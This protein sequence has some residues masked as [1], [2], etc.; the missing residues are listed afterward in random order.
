MSDRA[1]SRA[2]QVRKLVQQ[3]AGGAKGT[4]ADLLPSIPPAAPPGPIGFPAQL[5][6]AGAAPPADVA[7]EALDR[8][9][10]DGELFPGHVAAL[11]AIVLPT[12]RPVIDVVGDSFTPPQ[13]GMWAGLGQHQDAI[14]AAIRATGRVEL[15]NHPFLPYGGTAFLIGPD[16]LL[17]NR[18]VAEAFVTGLGAR[19]LRFYPGRSA[20]VD[21]RQ[22]VVASDP[23]VLQVTSVLLVHP[24][25]DAAVFRV[26]GVPADRKPLA[27]LA[28]PPADGLQ[29][30]DAVVIGYP[31][32]DPTPASNPSLQIQIFNGVFQRKRLQPGR[33]TGY[34]EVESYANKVQA[35]AHDCSTL[36][37]NS[38]SVVLDLKTGQVIGLHFAGQY[39]VSNYAVP[40]WALA[41]DAH[42]ADLG[43]SLSGPAER[44]RD[45]VWAP[46]WAQVEHAPPSPAPAAAAAVATAKG[47]E[48]P[49]PPGVWYERMTD[50]DLALALERDPARTEHRLEQAMGPQRAQALVATLRRPAHTEGLFGDPEPDPDKPTIVYLHGILGAHLEAA[51]SRVWLNPLAILLDNMARKLMLAPDGQ[52]EAS[53][54][55]ALQAG[56]HIKL[57][58][59]DAARAWRRAGYP[60]R[61]FSYDWRKGIAQAADRLH[62]FIEMLNLERPGHPMV[63]AAHSM[64]GLVSALY[65]HRHA[66]WADRV[67]RAV[68]FGPPLGGSFDASMFVM[69]VLPL[70]VK[71]RWVSPST[72]LDQLRQTAAS[73]P[74]VIDLL[75]SREFFPE[76][77]L[78]YAQAGWPD[79][80]CRPAQRWLDQSRALKPRLVDAPI[81][82]RTTVLMALRHGT[83][84]SMVQ[85]GARLVHGP[86][87]GT[88]DGTVPARSAYLHGL[89]AFEV[90]SPHHEIPNEPGAIRAVLDL[91]AT[92]RCSLPPV[93]L[94]ATRTLLPATEAP[95][96]LAPEAPPARVVGTRQRLREG[97]LRADDLEWLLSARS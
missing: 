66:T 97:D 43:A 52:R 15:V 7:Q 17:T 58:Y 82:Q 71:W 23:L 6:P 30:R 50:A 84:A 24:Y 13:G 96:A 67:Q 72:P 16:L 42:V 46:A 28:S 18:H 34:R 90:Q 57:F 40:A 60:V 65:S 44:P 70:I 83:V 78:L 76:V 26:S 35:L 93:S 87:T 48:D 37:G 4:V 85:E 11:E 80:G 9:M 47:R 41:Q 63:I 81:L 21:L 95:A 14:R 73:A 68:F 75:P 89:P 31:A 74:G 39:L 32:L 38:G 1:S 59:E 86:P 19:E 79:D 53:G 61:P 91:I 69:G 10:K 3:L 54:A 8:V 25:W 56:P 45:P 22:E 51:T 64:G 92:G 5:H 2:E 62:L 29:G 77:D 33:V 55:A 94:E 49:V 36:G 88:G 12:L 27:L 20:F